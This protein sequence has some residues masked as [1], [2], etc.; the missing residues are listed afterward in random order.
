MVS[1]PDSPHCE[2]ARWLL[3]RLAIPY[4]EESHAPVCHRRA[5]RALGGTGVVPL[6]NTSDATLDGARAVLDYYE[7]RCPARLRLYPSDAR[8]RADVRELFDLFLDGFGTAA[9]AWACAYMLPTN[10]ATLVRLWTAGAPLSERLSVPLFY[11]MLAKEVRRNL[12]I[13][14]DT[15][16][17]QRARIESTFER[18]EAR[19]GDGRR[20]L[21][22]ERFTAADLALS[23][24]AAP[25][26]LPPEYGGPMPHLEELPPEMRAGVEQLRARPAGQFILRLYREERPRRAVELVAA[27]EHE[28]GQTFKDRLFIRLTSPRLLRLVFK[29]LR[30]FRPILVIGKS[31]IVSRH[32]DCIE[33]LARDTDFT[34][35]EINEAR[36]QSIDGP[37]ILGMDRSPQYERESATLREAVHRDDLEFIRRFVAR[38]ALELTDAA[39]PYGRID[40]VSGLSRVVPLRLVDSYFGI[41]APDEPTMMRWMRDI[42]HDLFVNPGASAGVHRDASRSGA[43]L[44]RHMDDV[45]ARRKAKLAEPDQPDDMLGRL[46]ALQDEA[47]SWLD[48]NAVRRNLGGLIVGAVDT[49][50]KSVALAVDELL[51]RPEALDGARAA[52][53]AG[54]MDAMKRYVYEALRFNP[55][56]PAQARFCGR[57]TELAAGT[58]RARRIAAGTTLFL[59]TLSAMF[60]PEKFPEPDE[61]R[62]D[63]ETDTYLHFGYGM[64]RC[65]GYAING[66]Q[67]PELVAALLRLPNLRRAGGSGGQ[68]AYDGPF[69]QRLILEFDGGGGAS[70]TGERSR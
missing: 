14:P 37:F 65:F 49:T 67:I 19:L 70:A 60:D 36:F 9:Q 63:R 66:V 25:A 45:I 22:G 50:S 11:N 52:A 64:H 33:V 8:A 46:L 20:F 21:T 42:F 32:D 12:D 41:P 31:G 59:G 47:H 5:A 27:G 34:I 29:G 39:R 56:H 40:V 44:R 69:P 53:L 62:A 58:P 30:R 26:L 51:R 7:A 13:K 15:V 43:E 61:F 16:A 4:S 23:A 1:I 3:D 35:A 55:H 24:L 2:L 6:M 38:S 17:S 54:D 18:V 57:E 10:R 68:L 48:D 28:S